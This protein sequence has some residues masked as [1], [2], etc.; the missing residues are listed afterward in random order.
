MRGTVAGVRAGGAV[1]ALAVAISSQAYAG[2]TTELVSVGPNGVPANGE[3]GWPSISADG[4]SVTFEL[5][6][7]N[8]VAGD[9]NGHRDIFV[10]DRPNGTTTRVSAPSCVPRQFCPQ[11]NG[12]SD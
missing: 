6:A 10:H 7:T 5:D 2:I 4:G 3:S 1:L 11:S 8:L 12:N 9:T